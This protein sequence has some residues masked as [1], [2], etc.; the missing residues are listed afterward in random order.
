VSSGE[1]VRV[2]VVGAGRMGRTHLTA[3]AGSA[4][5][6]TTAVV[7]PVQPVREELAAEGLRTYE[8]LDELLAAGGVEAVLIAAPTDLHAEL[9]ACVAAAGL[10][11]LCEKPC[12]LRPEETAGAMRAAADAGVLLQIGYWRRF[13]PE[14]IALREQLLRGAL[15]E[16]SV[17]SCWQ[18]DAHPPAQAFRVRSGGILLDMGVHEF[19][20]IRWLTGSEIEDVHALPAAATWDPPIAEDPESVVALARLSGGAVATVSLGRRFPHGDCCWL[21]LMG[22][23]GYARKAFMWGEEGTRVFHGALVAQADAFAAAVR[24]EP[25]RGATGQDALRAIETAEHAAQSLAVV[26]ER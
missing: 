24:G 8:H 1:P 14:L 20:Q 13:V 19:D 16:L 12:G 6:K 26:T 15:G 5:V 10:P 25:Q 7:E 21:E 3:L 17:I 4:Q 23:D 22:T 9:V 18:W 2:A 11:I